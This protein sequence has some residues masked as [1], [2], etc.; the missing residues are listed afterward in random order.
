[1]RTKSK[2]ILTICTGNI[3]RSPM[4]EKLLQHALAAEDAPLN[5]LQVA[6][7]GVAAGYGDPASANSVAALKKV[8]LDLT[9]HKSQPVT[10]DLIK[11]A[12]V[13]FGMTQSHLDILRHYHH[14]LPERVHLFREFMGPEHDPEIPD[15]YGQNY[16]AYAACFDSMAEAIPSLVTY[17]KN[18][19]TG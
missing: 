10:D 17:L 3:C 5:Q 18:E 9:S 1:M 19:Y 4:A 11:E 12:F 7:A 6:S 13:I 8:Q 15:P 2:L 16:A 14:D